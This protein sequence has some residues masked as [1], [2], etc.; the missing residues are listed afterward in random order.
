MKKLTIA[1]LLVAGFALF[2]DNAEA[3]RWFRPIGTP[4]TYSQPAYNQGYT[5]GPTYGPAYQNT[6]PTMWQSMMEFERR[7]NAMIFGW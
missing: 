2:S 6:R 3:A 5:Y 4:R 1:L 7:K